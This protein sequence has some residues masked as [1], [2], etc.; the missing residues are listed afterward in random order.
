MRLKDG[1]LAVF[2]GDNYGLDYHVAVL[3]SSGT[4]IRTVKVDGRFNG[5]ALALPGGE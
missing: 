2:Y 5:L 1:H 3:D 4:V